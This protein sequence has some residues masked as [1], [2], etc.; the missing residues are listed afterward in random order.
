MSALPLIALV[1][2]PNAGKSALF[3][4]EGG[5]AREVPELLKKRFERT[6]VLSVAR[7]MHAGNEVRRLKI[8]ACH[9]YRPPDS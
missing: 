7:V 4:I 2:N 1:G 6:E 5:D 3:V 9:N 8:F